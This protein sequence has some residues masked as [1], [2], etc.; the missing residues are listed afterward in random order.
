[1]FNSGLT[2]HFSGGHGESR[3][4]SAPV[5]AAASVATQTNPV[6]N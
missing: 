1:M 4:E 2:Q 3:G 6:F 5:P